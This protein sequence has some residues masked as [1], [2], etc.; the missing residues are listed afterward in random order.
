MLFGFWSWVL[1]IAVV[2]GIFM[3]HRLPELREQAKE[4][5]K[6]GAEA[7]KKGHQDLQ[8]KINQKVQETKK[9]AEEKKKAKA[10]EKAAEEDDDE[11]LE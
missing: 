2:A 10:A 9:A 5:L 8:K 1:V 6:S 11:E 3:A 4:Q 7:L